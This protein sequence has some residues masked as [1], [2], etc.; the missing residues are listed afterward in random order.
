MIFRLEGSDGSQLRLEALVAVGYLA[1]VCCLA[2]LLVD[3]FERPWLNFIG[4]GAVIVLLIR[5]RAEVAD[6]IRLTWPEV[7]RSAV[8]RFRPDEHAGF[9]RC[10]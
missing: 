9:R 4:L 7:Q 5:E 6:H 1:L 10:Q 8:Q 2:D 3:V